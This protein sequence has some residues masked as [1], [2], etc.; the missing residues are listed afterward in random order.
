MVLDQFD[1]TGN[2]P[3]A[4]RWDFYHRGASDRMVAN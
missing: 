4:V 3:E 1:G 2:P